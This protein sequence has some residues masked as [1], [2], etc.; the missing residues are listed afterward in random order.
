MSVSNI[1]KYYVLTKRHHKVS[2]TSDLLIL[3][4][5]IFSGNFIK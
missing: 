2:V 3:F 4:K 1:W 5:Y